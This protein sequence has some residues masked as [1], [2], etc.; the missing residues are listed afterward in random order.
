MHLHSSLEIIQKWIMWKFGK[1][2]FNN[3]IGIVSSIVKSQDIIYKR[4]FLYFLYLVLKFLTLL[5]I[6]T[7]GGLAILADAISNSI[8]GGGQF[9]AFDDAARQRYLRIA[10]SPVL[11]LVDDDG[12]FQESL[13]TVLVTKLSWVMFDRNKKKKEWIRMNMKRRTNMALPS[14]VKA[15]LGE[16][17]G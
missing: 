8:S 16:E 9:A 17:K 10:I 3:A 4:K 15:Y 11:I 13:K 5:A 7:D 14:Q 6:I 2:I 1:G 12:R